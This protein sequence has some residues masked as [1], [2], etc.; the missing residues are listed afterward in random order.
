ML[1]SSDVTARVA[2]SP[3]PWDLIQKLTSTTKRPQQEEKRP[4]LG[5]SVVMNN[6]NTQS[7]KIMRLSITPRPRRDRRGC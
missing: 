6:P 2:A 1:E 5:I 4:L 3:V 7:E